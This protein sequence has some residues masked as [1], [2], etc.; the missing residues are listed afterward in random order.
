MYGIHR[1][2]RMYFG[3]MA[4]ALNPDAFVKAAAVGR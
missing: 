1:S 3:R 4:Q 2:Y